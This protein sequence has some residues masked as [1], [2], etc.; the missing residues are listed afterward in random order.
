MPPAP[1]QG[2]QNDSAGMGPIWIVAVICLVGLTV[3]Y[4]GHVYLVI[5]YFHLKLVEISLFQFFTGGLKSIQ[6]YIQNTDPESATFVQVG[7]VAKQVGTHIRFPIAAMLL[8]LGMVLNFKASATKY[9]NVYSMKSLV[10]AQIPCWP[11]L[12]P[13]FRL[14]L[15]KKDINEGPWS[16]AMQPMY[17]AKYY[18]LLAVEK[19]QHQEGQLSKEAI[20]RVT[21]IQNRAK[22]LFTMQ[23]GK[24]W[25]GVDDLP[26]HTKALFAIFSAKAARAS[27]EARDFLFKLASS[28]KEGI[29]DFSGTGELLKKHRDDPA[30]AKVIDKHAYVLTVMASLIELARLDGVLSCAD[31]LWLKPID[32]RLWFMLNCIG[33]QTAFVEVAGP[34]AHWLAEKELGR[35]IRSPMVDQAVKALE[36]AIKDVKYNPDT[37]R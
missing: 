16:M 17:F 34:F 26:I 29:V 5:A 1:P 12:S 25:K 31:F 7:L 35:K 19:L 11:Q 15:I 33:R 21:L 18:K 36:S 8:L 9:R 14:D 10:E 3:W 30:I 4:F 24:P 23:L 28:S 37:K 27:G 22:R 6:A 32:R 20:Y 13:T 2:G